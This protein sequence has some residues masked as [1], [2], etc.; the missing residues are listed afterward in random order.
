MCLIVLVSKFESV[1][2]R[3]HREERNMDFL[4]DLLFSFLFEFLPSLLEQK[5]RRPRSPE[6]Q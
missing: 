2:I 6:E 3:I 4:F 1:H 5:G